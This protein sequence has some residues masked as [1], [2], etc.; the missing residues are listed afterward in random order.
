MIIF[1]FRSIEG[2]ILGKY[3]LQKTLLIYHPPPKKPICSVDY[4]SQ[5]VVLKHRMIY[6][7][8]GYTAAL[9]FEFFIYRTSQ[10][11]N[12]ETLFQAKVMDT[13]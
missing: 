2:L 8:P 5:T 4:Q 9:H 1:G 3:R 10:I 6:C 7:A 13:Q 11:N 12:S